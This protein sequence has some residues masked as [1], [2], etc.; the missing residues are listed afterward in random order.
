MKK[1]IVMLIAT[2]CM[3]VPSFGKP[4]AYKV[5]SPSGDIELNVKAGNEVNYSLS[6]KGEKVVNNATIDMDFGKKKRPLK[7]K[8]VKKNSHNDIVSPL[9]P[10]KFS[11]IDNVYN[12]L[13]LNMDGNYAIEFRV[14]DDG[15]AH[16]FI[17]MFPDSINVMSETFE[18][19]VPEDSFM[20][21]QQTNGFKTSYEEPYSHKHVKEWTADEKMSTLPVLMENGTD[22]ALFCE[23]N[24]RDYP[25]FFLKGNGDGKFSAVFPKTPLKFGP[26]GD[27]SLKI[28]EEA[29]YIARTAGNRTFPW[30]WMNLLLSIT[31][32][33]HSVTTTVMITHFVKLNSIQIK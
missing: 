3:V 25:A 16:R 13:L 26:D 17:T 7:V 5:V 6:R 19:S 11:K 32:S 27:R 31:Q 15:V 8:G 4:T 29:P 14:M 23:T 33:Y 28:L 30:E 1:L 9:V 21:L 12:S 10:M 18:L 24:L 2:T 20:H 22:V